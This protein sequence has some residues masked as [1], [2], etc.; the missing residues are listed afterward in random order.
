MD[1]PLD[2]LAAW[3]L[4]RAAEAAAGL[5]RICARLREEAGE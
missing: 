3:G 5:A 1:S 4:S 2:R